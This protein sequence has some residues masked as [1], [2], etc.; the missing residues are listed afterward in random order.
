MKQRP[1]GTRFVTFHGQYRNIPFRIDEKKP[2][3]EA[4]GFL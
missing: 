3:A 1:T 2:P 4:S